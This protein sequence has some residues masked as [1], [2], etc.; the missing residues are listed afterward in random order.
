[1]VKGV[2][3]YV[4]LLSSLSRLRGGCQKVKY[5]LPHANVR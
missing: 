3:H 1:M 5:K 4:Q 2:A